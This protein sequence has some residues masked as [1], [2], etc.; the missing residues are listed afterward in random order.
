L[1]LRLDAINARNSL[2]NAELGLK[3][4]MVDFVTFLNLDKD[5]SVALKLP[6][7]P[8]RIDVSLESA[9]EYVRKNNPNYLYNQQQVLEAE[10]E[11]ERTRK[12]TLYD[13]SIAASVG[14]NQV[15]GTFG[16]AYNRPLQQDLVSVSLS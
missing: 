6:E 15:A 14:F 5:V 3:K 16:D 13:A 7:V 12:S 4:A 10:R 8:H 1:T 11:V 2:K 9:L